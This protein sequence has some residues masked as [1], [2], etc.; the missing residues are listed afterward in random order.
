MSTAV[1]YEAPKVGDI[2][3][4][5][6]GYDETNVDFYKVVKVSEF[7]VWFQA[8]GATSSDETGM[9][10]KKMPNPDDE[11]GKVFRRKLRKGGY[12]YGA[13][14]S[15]FEWATPWNGLAQYDSAGS[16]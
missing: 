16:R 15:S 12:S 9:S 4:S 13:E 5:S 1:E 11:R 7:S 10:R 2:W 6:W 14:I 3:D 8:I